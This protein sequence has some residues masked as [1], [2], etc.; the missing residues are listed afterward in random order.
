M[1]GNVPFNGCYRTYPAKKRRRNRIS[2]CAPRDEYACALC[3]IA[4]VPYVR[5][6]V[7]HSS[8]M[9]GHSGRKRGQM[10]D[11]V[12]LW[13]VDRSQ[14]AERG[15]RVVA[16]SGANAALAWKGAKL[17]V[18]GRRIMPVVFVS[19][20]RHSLEEFNS[21]H[22]HKAPD[23]RILGGPFFHRRAFS[24]GWPQNV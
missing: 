7:S 14:I 17:P 12:R 13:N 11:I 23:P 15:A 19:L 5:M 22:A 1:K 8:I 18:N 6:H 24:R 4:L 20:A 10:L 9:H 16:V 3:E 21:S 2:G